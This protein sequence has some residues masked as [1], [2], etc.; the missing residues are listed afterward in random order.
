MYHICAEK[1]DKM[2]VHLINCERVSPETKSKAEIEKKTRKDKRPAS[3]SVASQLRMSATLQAASSQ[4]S[5]AE[6]PQKRRK[7]GDGQHS[8]QV[9]ATKRWTPEVRHDFNRDLCDLLVVCG[10]AWNAVSNP[11]MKVFFDKWV[12]GSVLPD[13]RLLAGPILKER[14]ADVEGEIKK[15]VKGKLGT[16]SCDGWKNGSK[17]PVIASRCNVEFQVGLFG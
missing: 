12:A 2:I 4:T 6:P 11:Q 14:V 1:T 5:G 13:R 8:F 16:G 3:E 10:F 17:R 15:K 7:G 9:V